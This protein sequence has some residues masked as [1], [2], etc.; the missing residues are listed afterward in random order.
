[1]SDGAIAPVPAGTGTQDVPLKQR[2][3]YYR[4][5]VLRFRK[6]GSD[7]DQMY[8]A[9]RNSAPVLTSLNP[10]TN[11]NG[12]APFTLTITGT[13]FEFGSIIHF[14]TKTLSAATVNDTTI[15]VNI[16][17]GYDQT[18]AIYQVSVE[19]PGGAMS[20]SLPF[21]VT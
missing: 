12:S 5:K 6:A 16:P 13:G 19:S 11:P 18:P 9:L 4:G 21:T 20:N 3:Y 10:N 15:T 14:G 17:A 1:M 8:W 7:A 2:F